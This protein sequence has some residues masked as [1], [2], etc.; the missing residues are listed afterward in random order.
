MLRTTSRATTRFLASR[1]TTRFFTATPAGKGNGMVGFVGLGNMG[2]HMAANLLAKGRK[3]CV[4]DLS[5][6]AVAAAV[7]A[8]ATQAASPR[9]VAE[10]ASTIITMLPA[11][12]HVLSVYT[13]A[14]TGIFAAVQPGAVL[15]DSSTIDPGRCHHAWFCVTFASV[16][17]YLSL[18]SNTHS[19]SSIRRPSTPGS[20]QSRMSL[21]SII[22]CLDFASKHSLFIPFSITL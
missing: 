6:D 12:K 1:V 14:T 9:A 19:H 18:L 13:D 7:A 17:H 21:L 22:T 11:S 5:A 10:Q 20:V 16:N 3:V 2:G 4:F 15:I 8:G